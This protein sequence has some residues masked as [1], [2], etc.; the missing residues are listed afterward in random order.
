MAKTNGNGYVTGYLFDP[1]MK[2]PSLGDRGFPEAGNEYK[3]SA[4]VVRTPG[5]FI[6]GF[7]IPN[8]ICGFITPAQASE[9]RLKEGDQVTISQS[10]LPDG[11]YEIKYIWGHTIADWKMRPVWLNFLEWGIQNNNPRELVK[12]ATRNN[13]TLLE[14]A[15]AFVFPLI[16]G[17]SVIVF[18]PAGSSKSAVVRAMSNNHVGQVV[19]H[20]FLA[21]RTS[22]AWR[23]PGVSCWYAPM[24]LSPETGTY[25][26]DQLEIF[27]MWKKVLKRGALAGQNI[28]AEL[29]S[30]S[31]LARV[32]NLQYAQAAQ[33]NTMTLSGGVLPETIAAIQKL[34]ALA[35]FPDFRGMAPQ[36]ADGA[37]WVG[38]ITILCTMM[39]G[40]RD[41]FGQSVLD[42]LRGFA[43]SYL[44][45][46]LIPDRAVDARIPF[47]PDFL[48]RPA[49]KVEELANLTVQNLWEVQQ[50]MIEWDENQ[51]D[52]VQ[53]AM[54]TYPKRPDMWDAWDKVVAGGKITAVTHEMAA[55]HAILSGAAAAP[56]DQPAATPAVP[57]TPLPDTL[58]EQD[59]EIRA[60]AENMKRW[61]AA[62]GIGNDRIPRL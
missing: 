44:G 2:F 29:D 60:V 10:P 39:V 13:M 36:Y 23:V 49:E 42:Q 61:A 30:A 41:P 34:L 54:N 56:S 4:F 8:C 9:L 6:F 35:R 46:V 40:N 19:H 15:T 21:E 51:W 48:H 32:M 58:E 47:G 11:S 25:G 22:E 18:G 43:G 50:R 24:D 31:A 52:H 1:A 53:T 5:K 20:R 3:L 45:C 26:F 55:E 14:A 17:T 33:R 59:A 28:V 7:D 37:K 27:G 57:P 62:N 16:R 12:L 38:S